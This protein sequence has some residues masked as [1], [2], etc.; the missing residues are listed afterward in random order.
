[1]VLGWRCDGSVSAEK[2]FLDLTHQSRM[3]SQFHVVPSAR[4][5]ARKAVLQTSPD[6]TVLSVGGQL[7]RLLFP[8]HVEDGGRLALWARAAQHEHERQL[9]STIE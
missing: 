6:C 7:Q 9:M 3:S 5:H 1:M 8:R 2:P 4:S